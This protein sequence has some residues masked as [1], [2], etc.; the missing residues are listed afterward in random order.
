MTSA[1]LAAALVGALGYALSQDGK[2]SRADPA[3]PQTKP[4]RPDAAPHPSIPPVPGDEFSAHPPPCFQDNTCAG[5]FTGAHVRST[6]TRGIGGGDN[7]AAFKARNLELLTGVGPSITREGFVA[8]S[9]GGTVVA[10]RPDSSLTP[11]FSPE[12][13]LRAPPGV[14]SATPAMLHDRQ[15]TIRGLQSTMRGCNTVAPT[16][17]QLLVPRMRDALPPTRLPLCTDLQTRGKQNQLNPG[18]HRAKVPEEVAFSYNNPRL[19][20]EAPAPMRSGAGVGGLRAGTRAPGA[21]VRVGAVSGALQIRNTVKKVG[22]YHPPGAARAFHRRAND[23]YQDKVAPHPEVVAKAGVP[24]GVRG[25]LEPA[26]GELVHPTS[27]LVERYDVHPGPASK[28]RH[29]PDAAAHLTDTTAPCTMREG[30]GTTTRVAAGPHH[31]GLRQGEDLA[32]D[33]LAVHATLPETMRACDMVGSTPGAASGWKK[34]PTA[35]DED[36]TAVRLNVAGQ[37]GGATGH[38]KAPTAPNAVEAGARIGV[39]GRPSAPA[40][41]VKKQQLG[42]AVQQAGARVVA[43]LPQHLGPNPEGMAPVTTSTTFVG[44]SIQDA[45]GPP[46]A[47]AQ[48]LPASAPAV[49]FQRAELQTDRG[50]EGLAVGRLALQNNPYTHRK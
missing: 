17:T 10:G 41:A 50:F 31:L 23:P 3:A 22:A 42:G 16:D 29:V 1:V 39:S 36:E 18:R 33:N 46:R 48:R 20:Q 7:Y 40:A 8:G 44:D 5:D 30:D 43:E 25:G 4:V 9:T 45:P 35:P 26:R 2:Q 47:T 24:H 21:G 6:D 37:P 19:R 34:A 14:K 49:T 15:A 28:A 38:R 27:R 11:L 12:M 13:N 32:R